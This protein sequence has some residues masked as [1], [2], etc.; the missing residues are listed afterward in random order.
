MP[1]SKLTRSQSIL[2]KAC[3]PCMIR[4][5]TDR[6]GWFHILHSETP[7]RVEGTDAARNVSANEFYVRVQSDGRQ[8]RGFSISYDPVRHPNL[9][10]V[11][12]IMS[13][14][15]DAFPS[16]T[17]SAGA[18]SM[19]N[20]FPPDT[21][22]SR[23]IITSSCPKWRSPVAN[24]SGYPAQGPSFHRVRHSSRTCRAEV[25]TNSSIPTGSALEQ[26]SLERGFS[27]RPFR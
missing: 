4:S 18:V 3:S 9:D 24:S 1:A 27:T 25:V 2:A 13:F 11:V 22:L 7:G 21:I 14:T 26:T 6:T 5:V 15:F 10:R 17:N 23:Q 16:A 8:L 19:G 12:S 20:G